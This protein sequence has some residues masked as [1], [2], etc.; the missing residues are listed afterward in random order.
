[1]TAAEKQVREH[2][3]EL[4]YFF[5]TLFWNKASSL[6]EGDTPEN[7]IKKL[8]TEGSSEGQAWVDLKLKL[9]KNFP[10]AKKR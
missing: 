1:M 2:V 8:I 6:C 9:N 4:P 3:K 10:I 7:Y 5:R